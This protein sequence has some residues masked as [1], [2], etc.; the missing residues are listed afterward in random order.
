M[1]HRHRLGDYFCYKYKMMVVHGQGIKK[2]VCPNDDFSGLHSIIL[3]CVKRPSSPLS[4]LSKTMRGQDQRVGQSK[5]H[6]E[7][8]ET[9]PAQSKPIN[10]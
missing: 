2:K 1:Q 3:F 8:I 9:E 6:L 7:T 10:L 4:R 5:Q